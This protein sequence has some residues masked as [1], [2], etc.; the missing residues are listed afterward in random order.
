[1]SGYDPPLLFLC[2]LQT[3]CVHVGAVHVEA[4]RHPWGVGAQMPSPCFFVFLRW[5]FLLALE[6]TS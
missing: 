2:A 3:L 4:V 1:M 6:L 5:S